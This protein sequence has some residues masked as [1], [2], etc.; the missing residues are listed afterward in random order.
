LSNKANEYVDKEKYE[1]VVE[2]EAAE[3]I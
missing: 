3:S 1:V 2:K